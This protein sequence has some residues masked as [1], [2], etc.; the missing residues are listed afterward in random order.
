MAYGGFKDLKRKTGADKV[1]RD[2]AFNINKNQRG[3]DL[4][5][6][7]R[8]D[9]KLLVAVSKMKIFLIKSELQNYA[10]QLLENLHI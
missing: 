9:K 8:F 3:L 1:L 6:Y 2:K 10:N 5:V 7:K 4:M